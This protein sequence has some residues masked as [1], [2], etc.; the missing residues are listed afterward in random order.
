MPIVTST[1][2]VG[3][4]QQDGRRYVTEAHTDG[5]GEVYRVEYLAAVGGRTDWQGPHLQEL[6]WVYGKAQDLYGRGKNGRFS[7]EPLEGVGAAIRDANNTAQ[8]YFHKHAGAGTYEYVPGASTG[9]VPGAL[10]APMAEKQAYGDVGRWDTPGNTPQGLPGFGMPDS[11]GAGNRDALYSA[12]GFRQ[13]PSAPSSGAY[14]NAAGAMEHNPA[15]IARPLLDFPTGGT[16]QVADNTQQVMSAAERF[17]AVMDAQEAGAWNLPNTMAGVKGK[18]A[19]LLDSRAYAPAGADPALGLQPTPEQMANLSGMLEG[20]GHSVSATSRGAAI[21]PT[22]DNP[23]PSSNI[24]R[25]LG[26]W[27][28][29]EYP[30]TIQP[31]SMST[32]YV[33]GIGKWGEG[34]IVPTA[35]YSGEATAGLMGDLAALS[36]DVTRNMG[37]SEGI[38][39]AIRAK[40]TRDAALPGARGDIQNTRNFFAEADWPKAVQ[41]MRQGMSAAGAMA[42]LGYSMNSMAADGQTR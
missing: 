28:T 35:P 38:R 1:H 17:R 4:A 20:T 25:K 10:Q 19:L 22:G 34:G 12:I 5:T 39:Q 9:H 2:T 13:L 24:A 15:T 26:D 42:A 32:G 41:L 16:G 14:M 31:A 36:P 21:F 11:V 40:T 3:H 30:S 27:M 8:D 29:A 7:G 33:P 23:M 18:N 37:E 6:P